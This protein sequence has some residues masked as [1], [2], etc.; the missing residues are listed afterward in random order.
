MGTWKMMHGTSTPTNAF[1]IIVEEGY[2]VYVSNAQVTTLNF[3]DQNAAGFP[4]GSRITV[5]GKRN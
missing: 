4:T 3:Y 1:D 2:F 5:Y